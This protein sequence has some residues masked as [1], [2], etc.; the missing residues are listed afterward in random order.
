MNRRLERLEWLCVLGVFYGP[1]VVVAAFMRASGQTYSPGGPRSGALLPLADAMNG[2]LYAL[3]RLLILYFVCANGALA[4]SYFGRRWMPGLLGGAALIGLES[5]LGSALF[6]NNYALSTS[7]LHALR[8]ALIQS[9]TLVAANAAWLTTNVVFEELTRAYVVNRAEDIWRRRWLGT[10]A[11]I[12]LFSACHLYYTD[13]VLIEV[14]LFGGVLY[15]IWYHY[16]RN[17]VALGVAHLVTNT[18][19]TLHLLAE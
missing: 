18:V 14:A 3:P 5:V 13:E 1:L 6:G 12:L 19:V 16:A 7:A 10:L 15:S 4:S 11:S 8:D 2:C 9:P 17:V